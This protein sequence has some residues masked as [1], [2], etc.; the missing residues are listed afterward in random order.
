MDTKAKLT[1]KLDILQKALNRAVKAN[2]DI[3]NLAHS[4]DE[5]T[6]ALLN[7]AQDSFNCS[8][9]HLEGAIK[10]LRYEVERA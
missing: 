8:I 10:S 6:A 1:K 5:D 3:H 7:I 9:G 4:A 2:D